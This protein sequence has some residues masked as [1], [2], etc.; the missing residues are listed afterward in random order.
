MRRVYEQEMPNVYTDFVRL[1]DGDCQSTAGIH[2]RSN[3]DYVPIWPYLA[4]FGTDHESYK[5]RVMGLRVS[6]W[7]LGWSDRRLPG[8][9]TKHLESLENWQAKRSYLDGGPRR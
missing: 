3:G 1:Y 8:T 6:Q 9:R 5:L 4:M 7:V 2:I